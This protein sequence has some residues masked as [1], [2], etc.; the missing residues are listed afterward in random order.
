MCSFVRCVDIKYEFS[1]Y[2]TWIQ[3]KLSTKVN[4]INLKGLK[5]YYFSV[6]VRY[7]SHISW[8]LEVKID[9]KISAVQKEKVLD[10]FF[11]LGFTPYKAEQPLW[12][13]E[14]QEKAKKD[15]SIQ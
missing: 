11:L 13:M 12:G 5:V 15:Y 2:K 14:L 6:P 10:Y 8:K 3:K 4:T 9:K 7:H 1:W